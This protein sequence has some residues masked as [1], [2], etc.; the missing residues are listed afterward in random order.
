MKTIQ[1]KENDLSVGSPL[2]WPVYAHD[3]EL[4]LERGQLLSSERQKRILL[5]RGLY[6]E[7]NAGETKELEKQEKFS[8]ASPFNVLDAIRQNVTRILN[9]MNQSLTSDYNQRVTKVASVIQK[10]CYENTDAALGAIILDQQ[11]LYT[12]IHPI[13]CAILSELLLRRKNS[14]ARSPALSGRRV[15]AKY[16][17]AEFAR[18]FT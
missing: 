11:A 14:P 5:T 12:E 17:H 8:L 2:P 15:N 1:L 18:T 4:L 7:A 9:D 13:M 10:L 16:R 3:G 6:R